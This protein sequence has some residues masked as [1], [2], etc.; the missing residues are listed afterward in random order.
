MQHAC[1]PNG[2]L[3]QH[4]G[5]WAQTWNARRCD[6]DVA[7]RSTFETGNH[8]HAHV[9]AVCIRRR[10]LKRARFIR[11]VVCYSQWHAQVE[12]ARETRR[13]QIRLRFSRFLRTLWIFITG[14]R[15]IHRVL[16]WQATYSESIARVER[17]EIVR[18]WKMHRVKKVELFTYWPSFRQL[19]TRPSYS[20]R[21]KIEWD[22]CISLHM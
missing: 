11:V 17:N 2:I 3:A 18:L 16:R 10:P 8:R 22:R 14:A 9:H 12:N 7:I 19:L 6:P 5:F 13:C 1:F 4:D 20:E 15:E 21:F